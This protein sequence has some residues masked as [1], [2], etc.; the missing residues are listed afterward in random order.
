MHKHAGT[1]LDQ[2]GLRITAA[3]V[4]GHHGGLPSRARLKVEVEG[5]YACF[6]RPE[7]KT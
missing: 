4:F 6:T 2:Q 3:I 5:P 1:W 7:F